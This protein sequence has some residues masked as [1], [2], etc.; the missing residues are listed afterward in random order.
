LRYT[1]SAREYALL[2]KY[3][4]SR[5]QVLKRRVPSVDTVQRII[6]GKPA[7]RARGPSLG[8]SDKGKGKEVQGAS[9]TPTWALPSEQGTSTA[10]VAAGDYNARAIRHSIRVFLATGALM[11][12]WA[13]VSGKFM[14]K[15]QGFVSPRY[16]WF[17]HP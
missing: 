3:I 6:D 9:T 8:K 11:K 7:G 12:L 16:C 15:K 17:S 14:G 5:S 1:V 13:I 4:L 2:H 10:L